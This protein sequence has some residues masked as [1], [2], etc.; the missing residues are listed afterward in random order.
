[1]VW[2]LSFLKSRQNQRLPSFLHTGTTELAHGLV[3]LCMAPISNISWRC[4]LTSSY[5]W[6]S[7][8][9]YLSLKGVLSLSLISCWTKE[10]L[11]S[12]FKFRAN[13]CWYSSKSF[14]TEY[15][16]C[17][18]HDS[19]LVGSNFS[20]IIDILSSSLLG[21]SLD[22]LSFVISFITFPYISP[23]FREPSKRGTT[24][25]AS[26]CATLVP[27]LNFSVL[28]DR[29]YRTTGILSDPGFRI[30]SWCTTAISLQYQ[31]SLRSL[32]TTFILL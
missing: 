23:L 13:K 18:V 21:E 12:S 17:S 8:L 1:M 7:I 9:L 25:L 14:L 6:G 3:D 32:T 11:S 27:F 19:I 20:K 4:F 24:W 26:T 29:F 15:C 5:W 28:P 2:L 31:F 10:V 16:C 22:C 30:C